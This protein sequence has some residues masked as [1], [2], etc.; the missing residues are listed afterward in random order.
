MCSVVITIYTVIIKLKCNVKRDN[1][2]IALVMYNV[3][4][5]VMGTFAPGMT[6][7]ALFG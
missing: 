5:S 7:G 2:S 6:K 3:A 4:A 1:I